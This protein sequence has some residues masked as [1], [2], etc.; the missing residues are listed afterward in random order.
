MLELL[1]YMK[2]FES[3]MNDQGNLPCFIN[4]K[5]TET[6]KQCIHMCIYGNKKYLYNSHQNIRRVNKIICHHQ[7]S[8]GRI[9]HLAVGSEPLSPSMEA[10]SSSIRRKLGLGE[11]KY[12]TPNSGKYSKEASVMLSAYPS[13][14]IVLVAEQVHISSPIRH[15]AW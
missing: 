6:I 15:R 9:L 8:I 7:P 13:L 1:H 5:R 14:G 12:R 10:S 4:T 2:N 3:S 11:A